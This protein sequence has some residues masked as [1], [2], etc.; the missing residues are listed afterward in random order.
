MSPTLILVFLSAA[1]TIFALV[2]VVSPFL[3]S[4]GEQI[5]HELLDDE[6][7]EIERLVARKSVLLQSLKD[8][9]FDRETGKLAEQDYERL[10]AR[11]E[12]EALQ[13]MRA[14]DDLRGADLDDE[15]DRAVEERL[16]TELEETSS[17]TE[18][19]APSSTSER[20][21]EGSVVCPECD[22][23]LDAEARYC[24]RCGT[25]IERPRDGAG[26]SADAPEDNEN[27]HESD[28][29]RERTATNAD[30]L[31]EPPAANA[32]ETVTGDLRSE[33]TG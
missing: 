29:G 16:E 23:E 12:R 6:L 14:L 9:E 7:R 33:A 3:G 8:I 10:R 26:D 22:K 1:L 27:S 24:I 13:V 18:A 31:E 20:P 15:I 11:Y 19:E 4:E 17:P 5:R 25:A 28:E 32:D 30:E 2:R 21:A